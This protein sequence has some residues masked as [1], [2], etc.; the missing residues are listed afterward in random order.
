MNVR[1][2]WA[3]VHVAPHARLE[4]YVALHRVDL[5]SA[6]DGWY[7]G[8]GATERRGNYFGYLGRNTR[9]AGGLGTL[10]DGGLEWRAHR[11]WTLRGYAAA[12]K[13]GDAV[14]AVFAGRTLVTTAFEARLRF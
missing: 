12:M 9:G 2:V 14:A 1:E 5:A 7:F 3:G 13:G 11:W 10:V 4:T 6:A 8:S